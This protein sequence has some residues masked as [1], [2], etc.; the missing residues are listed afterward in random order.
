MVFATMVHGPSGG[1]GGV[2]RY[3]H[4]YVGSGHFFGFKI[5][6]FNVLLGFQKNKYF[7]RYEDF[8]DI[9]GYFWIFS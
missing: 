4:T 5:L 7:F 1:G 8:V 3:F 6:N 2:L 9:F